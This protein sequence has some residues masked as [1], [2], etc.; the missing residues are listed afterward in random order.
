M[1]P[2]SATVRGTKDNPKTQEAKN[3][4]SNPTQL[5][6]PGSLKTETNSSVKI[7][8]PQQQDG[9]T[10]ASNEARHVSNPNTTPKDQPHSAR[11]RG[12]LSHPDVQDKLY[13]DDAGMV[14]G[15]S[16]EKQ[17]QNKT[18]LGDHTSIEAESSNTSINRGAGQ[19][20]DQKER[21]EVADKRKK[22][23]IASKL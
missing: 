18:M 13:R 17:D 8:N 20:K 16:G 12:T 5:G 14:K 9:A 15:K 7:P 19:P 6:D 21:E 4:G 1:A 23:E 11:V 3:S 22:A 10:D 2:H